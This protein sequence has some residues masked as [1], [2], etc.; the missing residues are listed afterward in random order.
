[1]LLFYIIIH[2]YKL[3]ISY[4]ISAYHGDRLLFT[5]SA[6]DNLFLLLWPYAV[7]NK[8]NISCVCFKLKA[9]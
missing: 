1:M 5:C 6:E 8:L 7:K 2:S 9:F 4:H 3:C